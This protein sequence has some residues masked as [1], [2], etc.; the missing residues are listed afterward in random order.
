MILKDLAPTHNSWKSLQH[1]PNIVQLAYIDQYK[2]LPFLMTEYLDCISLKEL[3]ET[4]VFYTQENSNSLAL[5]ILKLCF[6]I[7]RALDFAH[8]NN[9]LHSNLKPSNILQKR[10]PDVLNENFEIGDQ[11]CITDFG[12]PYLTPTSLNAPEAFYHRG[13]TESSKFW[14][15]LI[16]SLSHLHQGHHSFFSSFKV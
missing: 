13:F 15:D 16:R 4:K 8:D 6:S 2:N 5:K 7:C 10:V 3:V 11:F 12:S 1:H 14:Y 9:L